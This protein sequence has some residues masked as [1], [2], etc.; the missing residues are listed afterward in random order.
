VPACIADLRLAAVSCSGLVPLERYAL[1]RRRGHAVRH[2]IADFAGSIR[3]ASLPGSLPIAR[4][5]LLTLANPQHR[6][7]TT[8]HVAHL[9][10]DIKG[11][12]SQI[13]SGSCEPGDY[14]G[15]PL[16]S[17][18]TSPAVGIPGEAGLGDVCSDDGKAA[19]LPAATIEQVDDLSG[20]AT[21]TSVP[22]LTGTAPLND[23]I[24]YGPFTALAQTGLSTGAGVVSP[25]GAK[26]SLTL[27]HQG[28][29][30]IAFHAANVATPG[31]RAVRGLRPGVY[32]ATWIVRDLNGDTRT[33][34]TR[35]VEQR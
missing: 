29:K 15:A 20:G 2:A 31:G 25:T 13:A 24:V 34:L 27:R 12:A 14:W 19:G 3:I 4:G 1:T 33:M 16:T 10:V 23:A 28:S 30:R 8:L 22:L 26:V 9:R 11:T 17:E 18:P 32:L 7:L 21:K 5:D 35:F 6:T